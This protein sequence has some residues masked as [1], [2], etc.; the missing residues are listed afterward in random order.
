VELQPYASQGADRKIAD[1]LDAR[2]KV[3]R[4][5]DDDGLADAPVPAG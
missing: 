5:D 2:A 1:A 3:E 4:P